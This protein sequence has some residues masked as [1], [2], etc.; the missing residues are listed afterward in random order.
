MIRLW[1]ALAIV[2]LA[3][4]EA[5]TTVFVATRVDAVWR[6]GEALWVQADRRLHRL[7]AGGQGAPVGGSA[8]GLPVPQQAS[9][10]DVRHDRPLWVGARAFGP[11]TDGVDVL[12]EDHPLLRRPFSGPPVR[13]PLTLPGGGFV[14]PARPHFLCRWSKG[15]GLARI[16]MP[17]GGALELGWGVGD[18]LQVDLVVPH[19][20]P[21]GHGVGG[22]GLLVGMDR[23]WALHRQGAPGVELAPPPWDDEQG[24]LDF[25]FAVPPLVADV[26]GDDDLDL[27]LVDPS[28]GSVALYLDLD[29]PR[30][31]PT[32]LILVD[33]L[34]LGAWAGDFDGDGRV[35]LGLLRA[36][37]PGLP[38]QVRILTEG[39]MTVEFLL[40]PGEQGG[41][42]PKSPTVRLKLEIGIDIGIRNEV[43]EAAFSSLC[44]PR[45]GG[46]IVTTG[47]S[48]V[49][50]LPFDGGDP[51]QVGALP[52]GRPLSPFRVEDIGA[53]FAFGWGGESAERVV[54]IKD[55]R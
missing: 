14:V 9:F 52:T 35:D 8:A 10:F 50:R 49:R 34:C 51:V 21:L 23:R 2:G 27:V 44:V 7:T 33:G 28:A 4:L 47:E 6:D 38:G 13:L 39:T 48:V 43:R 54:W 20:L 46:L 55:E 41:T 24:I 42:L 36:R 37:K 19:L 15:G 40:Y 17:L 1:T 16:P 25:P 30:P 45:R 5:Q 31:E 22:E 18:Y 29:A 32:R 3:S 53:G 26:G 11:A 12:A